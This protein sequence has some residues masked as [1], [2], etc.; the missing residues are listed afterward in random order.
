MFCFFITKSIICKGIAFLFCPLLLLF[1][2]GCSPAVENYGQ[3]SGLKEKPLPKEETI[4]SQKDLVKPQIPPID[5]HIADN[6][7]TAT[8]ALG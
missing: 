4:M 6:L 5:Q 2:L 3:N 7:E 1:L 8:F